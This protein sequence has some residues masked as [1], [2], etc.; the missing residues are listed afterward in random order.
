MSSTPI[1]IKKLKL[2]NIRSFGETYLDFQ[3]EDGTLPQ[4]TL[5]VGDNGIGKSTL[6]HSIAWMRPFLPYKKDETPGDDD[7]I[8]APIINDEENA[9]LM[10]LVRKVQKEYAGGAYIKA[11]F[12]AGRKL[13]SADS[14]KFDVCYSAMDIKLNDEGDLTDV[15]PKLR[16]FGDDFYNNEVLVYAYSASRSLGKGNLE[17]AD[18]G[19]TIPGFIN[20]QTELYDVQELFHTINYASLGAKGAEGDNYTAF[21]GRVK[22]MLVSL[23]PDLQDIKDIKVTTP[24]LVNN[25]LQPAQF[26]FTTRHGVDIPFEDFSLGYK[27]VISW[28]VDLAW[29]LFNKYSDSKNPLAEPAIVLLDEIDLHLHPIW[30]L[31]IIKNLS[32]HFPNVQFIATAHSPLMIQAATEANYAVVKY[33]DDHVEVINEPGEIDGWRVDQVLTSVFFGLHTARGPMYDQLLRRRDSLA[34]QKTLTEEERVELINITEQLSNFPVGGTPN[35]IAD[36]QLIQA[37]IAD[38]KGPKIKI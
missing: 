32:K 31:D 35:E 16:A 37:I 5:I 29:R 22:K 26:I 13:N 19:D 9:V 15:D 33:I 23:L 4:W 8:P 25:K 2:K 12:Q 20:D 30:Q 3:N 18:L 34:S 21:F 28:S 27:T 6:L 10:G 36:R 1:Y 38:Y 24:K 7:L 14:S 17:G 11:L